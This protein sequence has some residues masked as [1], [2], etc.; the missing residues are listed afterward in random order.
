MFLFVV[1]FFDSHSE[2]VMGY[3]EKR[4]QLVTTHIS[5]Q[6][7]AQAKLLSDLEGVKESDIIDC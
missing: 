2:M 7:S 4:D 5:V 1:S 3:W 6:C